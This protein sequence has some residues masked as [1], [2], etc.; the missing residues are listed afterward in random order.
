MS[1]DEL[2]YVQSIDLPNEWSS[3]A[4]AAV[5]RWGEWCGDFQAISHAASDSGASDSA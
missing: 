4:H 3:V 2:R 1:S 5:T